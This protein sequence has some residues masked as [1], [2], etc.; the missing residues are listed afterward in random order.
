MAISRMICYKW[1]GTLSQ[2]IKTRA[3]KRY[4]KAFCMDLKAEET[5][6][7]DPQP[8]EEALEENDEEYDIGSEEENTD[9]V[10][11][12]DFI[13]EE[14]IIEDFI[15]LE[16]ITDFL[17]YQEL[18]DLAAKVDTD[19]MIDEANFRSRSDRITKLYELA[20]Q[21]S[22]EKN[23]PFANASN[24]KY[25]LL[26]KAA[27]GFASLAYPA[28]VKD[29]QVVKGKVIGSD[30][31]DKVYGT[32]D[33]KPL[34]DEETGQELRRNKGIK[35]KAAARVSTFM[36]YDILEGM[37]GWE[38]DID[39][40]LH[41][42]PII[43]GCF[44]KTFRDPIEQKN[45]S[46]LVMPQ[47]L[48]MNIDAQSVET[49]SR[50]TE[51]VQMYPHEIQ[52]YINAGIF[53]KFDYTFSNETLKDN[54]DEAGKDK[55]QGSVHDDQKPHV[56]I[57]QHRRI[58]LDKDGYSEPY[59]VW[60]HKET[61]QI[62]RILPRFDEDDIDVNPENG[63]IIKIRP[64][65]FY[66]GFEFFP[67]PEGSPYGI[68]FGH[69]LED[70]NV[71]A[72]SS[73]NQLIDQG[74]LYTAGGGFIG[75][76]LRMKSGNLT[77]QP[78][79][80]KKVASAGGTIRDNV[81][82]LPVKEPSAILM[83]LLEFLIKAA[84]DIS[85]MTKMMA[86][87]IPA[88][89]P[90]TTAMA[91]L[92]QGMQPF[93]AVFKRVHRALKGEF[94]RLHYLN[95]RYIDPNYYMEVL[96]D[97][98]ADVDYDFNTKNAD[99]LPIS[100]PDMMNNTQQMIRAAALIELKDDPLIDG[101]EVRRRY[102]QSLQF[103]DVDKLV[104]I[105]PKAPNEALEAQKAVLEA[106]IIQMKMEMELR[107]KEFTLK[108]REFAL[109]VNKTMADVTEQRTKALKNVA[110]AEAAE[111]GSQ[112]AVYDKFINNLMEMR[113]DFNAGQE[114]R[115]PPPTTGGAGTDNGAGMVG[116]EN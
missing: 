81:F 98:A 54:Y 89:M 113:K 84:E 61:K 49:A 90:A 38:H 101:V 80:W 35:A 31:G 44:K 63:D 77:F 57:E 92:E 26:T 50:T 30:E 74:H 105:P 23:Y 15:D 107:Q 97:E 116:V 17:T 13:I 93:K 36:S 76:G 106:Q 67:D 22:R 20:L 109:K 64:Q 29:D 39:K 62:A 10:Y 51:L 72:N 5:K 79:E 96:N 104:K 12:E 41:I 27:I 103:S 115:E 2:D 82:P 40:L 14:F 25:P 33:G 11:I 43:G 70:I 88:N 6:D 42:I 4:R 1:T 32:P 85:T 102:L 21:V 69:L 58:D 37:G 71:A 9:P 34:V 7:W 47:F 87:E 18:Q 65:S 3:A 94:K 45:V 59:I 16:N 108:E 53:R 68:G 111:Q 55:E 83:A 110:D 114:R 112:L 99:I 19:Y 24:V 66:H 78:N 91:A 75:D 73:I 48:I 95:S 56:F 52:E 100:D 28:I 86:G 46:K 60:M 8:I